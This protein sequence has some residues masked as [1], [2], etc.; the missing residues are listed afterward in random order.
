MKKCEAKLEFYQKE[1]MKQAQ[2]GLPYV[3]KQAVCR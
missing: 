2:R 3:M 1:P